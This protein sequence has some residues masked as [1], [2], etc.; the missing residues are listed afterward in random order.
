MPL[1]RSIALCSA[2]IFTVCLVSAASAGDW[3]WGCMGRIGNQQ[4]LFSRYTLVIAAATPS[5]GKLEELFQVVDLPEKFPEAEAYDADQSNDGLQKTMTYTS[6]SNPKIKLTLTEKS[7]KLI[8]HHHHL[9]LRPR[10]GYQHR[11]QDLSRRTC[12]RAAG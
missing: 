8:A 4:I 1:S 5:L 11:A 2:F 10:R 12:E 7:S 6:R 3:Q 9:D